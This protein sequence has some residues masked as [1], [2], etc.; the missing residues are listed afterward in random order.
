MDSLSASHWFWSIIS[1]LFVCVQEAADRD[2]CLDNRDTFVVWKSDSVVEILT[3]ACHF[4]MIACSG[5]AK[6]K[7]LQLLHMLNLLFWRRDGLYCLLIDSDSLRLR[8]NAERGKDDMQQRAINSLLSLLTPLVQ[9]LHSPRS[10][11]PGQSRCE[12]P[13]LWWLVPAVVTGKLLSRLRC[14]LTKK[15]SD[16]WHK[17]C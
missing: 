7:S 14:T 9:S 3:T 5:E 13:G 2:S 11:S 1:V 17:L 12:S 16:F 8:G 4:M 15:K 6:T 10:Q